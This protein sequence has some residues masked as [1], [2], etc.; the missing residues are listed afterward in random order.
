VRGAVRPFLYKRLTR[1]YPIYW[2]VTA[3]VIL[4]AMR[5]PRV[6]MHAD[7]LA[8][9]NV[10]MS[11]LL[12]PQG[13]E[14]VVSAAWTLV[15]EMR[16]YVMFGALMLLP[17]RWFLPMM[18]AIGVGSV[19]MLHLSWVS[20]AT[21]HRLAVRV[22][23]LLVHPTT[24]EFVLGVAAGELYLRRA[25][26]PWF[27]GA[28]L[29]A[30]LVL[31]LVALDFHDE[32]LGNLYF[33]HEVAVYA[34][35]AFLLVLGVVLVERRWSPRAPRALVFLGDASYSLYLVHWPLIRIIG[36]GLADAWSGH[37][38]LILA[39]TATLSVALGAT[40]YAFVERPMLRL[41]RRVI[42]RRAPSPAG[43]RTRPQVPVASNP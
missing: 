15:H 4:V 40:T 21:M 12:L 17:R 8:P 28:V 11:L 7:D 1:I 42:A 19:A 2:L 18:A 14:P 36:P 6:L 5:S 16:F 26:R 22:A 37:P 10:V 23:M 31:M 38:W 41:A 20:P 30:G 34:V 9:R 33:Y 13:R 35:P 32:I 3:A 29:G 24:A 27:D 39:T 43:E 25:T